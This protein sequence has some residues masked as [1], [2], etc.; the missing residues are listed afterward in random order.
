VKG[1]KKERNKDGGI[2]LPHIQ[3]VILVAR[4]ASFN[5]PLSSS[6]VDY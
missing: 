3:V 4:E 2:S 6:L 5:K 1:K